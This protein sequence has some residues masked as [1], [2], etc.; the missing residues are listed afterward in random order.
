MQKK[1]VLSTDGQN[2][3]K[4]QTFWKRRDFKERAAPSDNKPSWGH[5]GGSEITSALTVGTKISIKSTKKTVHIRTRVKES[6]SSSPAF[7]YLLSTE[8]EK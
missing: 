5:E 1:K 6:F 8:E 2:F 4:T 7:R 3:S